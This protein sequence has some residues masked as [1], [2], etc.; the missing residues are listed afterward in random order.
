MVY[1]RLPCQ[2]SDYFFGIIS[3]ELQRSDISRVSFLES[4]R[5]LALGAYD[6]LGS[7]PYRSNALVRPLATLWSQIA[8]FKTHMLFQIIVCESG[9]GVTAHPYP[10][11]GVIF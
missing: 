7:V 6:V 8:S 9:L 4:V 2:E 10:F 1:N 11:D 3:S 5:S